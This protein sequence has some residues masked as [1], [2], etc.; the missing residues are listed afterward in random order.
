MVTC[1]PLL[2][3]TVPALLDLP[4]TTQSPRLSIRVL[5][6]LRVGR[7]TLAHPHT[8]PLQNPAAAQ[9]E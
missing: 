2:I 4:S 1:W 5:S 3:C 7:Y 9:T 6:S 8:L